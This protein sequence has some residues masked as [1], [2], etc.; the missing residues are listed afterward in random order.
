MDRVVAEL[1]ALSV[2]LGAHYCPN[3][4][5][6]VGCPY[7]GHGSPLLRV[8]VCGELP[9]LQARI[10]EQRP[11]W[12]GV[13]TW[14]QVCWSRGRPDLLTRKPGHLEPGSLW[15]WGSRFP[16]IMKS[17]KCCQG[18]NAKAGIRFYN[19]NLVY[20][21]FRTVP[22]ALKQPRSQAV[23]W[24]ASTKPS[25]LPSLHPPPLLPLP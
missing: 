18:N 20:R 2:V 9:D 6:L 8:K 7:T 14:S 25:P 5:K 21:L 10:R 11:L 13:F 12:R 19:L 3:L 22:E 23:S 4:C 15:Y 1:K 16:G 17:S 24:M